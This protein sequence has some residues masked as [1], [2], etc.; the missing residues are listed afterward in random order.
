MAAGYSKIQATKPQTLGYALNDSPTGLA[1]WITEKFYTWTDCD[2]NIENCISRD[3]PV[4]QHLAVL[5]SVTDV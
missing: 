4:D 1:A 3:P 5:V 2:G